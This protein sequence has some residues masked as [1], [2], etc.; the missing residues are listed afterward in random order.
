MEMRTAVYKA[1]NQA[2]VLENRPVPEPGP[3]QILIRVRACGI[4]G[5]DIHASEADHTPTNV[6]MG[7][8]FAGDI[9][10]VGDKVTRWKL[11]DAVVPLSQISCGE[12]PA[13]LSGDNSH[14]ENLQTLEFNPEYNGAYAEYAIVGEAD[15]LPLPKGI[16]YA[17]AAAIE[18]MAVGYDAVR[19]SDLAM[20]D[21]VLIIGAGPIGLAV[22]TWASHFGITHVVVSEMNPKR[23]ALA[24]QMGA[25]ATINASEDRDVIAAYQRMT[26]RKPSVIFEVVGVPGM[27]QRCI[28]MAE[29]DSK[30]VVVGVCQ[31]SD[32]FEPMQCIFKTL[33]LIFVLGYTVTDYATIVSLLEQERITVDP[34]ITHR[35]T[36]EELPAMFEQM[37]RPT[38]QMK[39]IV[40]PDRND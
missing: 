26:G 6:V 9:A 27:I 12:C 38:D 13:C 3:R 34:L 31:E 4:C 37:R 30:I 5:S 32:S 21:A 14:C 17:Q 22:A 10:A 33:K 36:L 24:E 11:G 39:V 19:R 40:E 15:A 2:L 1:K 23:L 29:P 20:D 35:I 16:S 7:H 8:E 28:E 18:P 25:T